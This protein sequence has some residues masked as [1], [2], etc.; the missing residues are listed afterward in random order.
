MNLVLIYASVVVI[1]LLFN[2]IVN[3]F[4]YTYIY[5]VDAI[6]HKSNIQY[7]ILFL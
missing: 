5:I 1:P 6:Q 3:S 2:D 7:L 4:H